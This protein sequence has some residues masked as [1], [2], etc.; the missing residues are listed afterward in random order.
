MLQKLLTLISSF[1]S[2]DGLVA[3][4]QQQGKLKHYQH[5][6]FSFP[7]EALLIPEQ[8]EIHF[9]SVDPNHPCYKN[10]II[11]ST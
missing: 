1:P 9:V 2:C 7:A 4:F 10:P 3:S 5:W 11:T 6:K 8:A